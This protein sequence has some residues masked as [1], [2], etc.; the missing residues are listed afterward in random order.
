VATPWQTAVGR[1]PLARPPL[2]TPWQPWQTAVA[3]A[4]GRPPWQTAVA[5]R[6]GRPPWQ[7][8]VADR[9]GRP[10]WQTAV[11]DRRGRPP[12]QTAVADRRGRP[13]WQT[14]VGY[15]V[16][17]MTVLL[18]FKCRS[19][20][21]L[22]R[23]QH[24][25]YRVSRRIC[26]VA[27]YPILGRQPDHAKQSKR[28]AK[29]LA[30]VVTQPHRERKRKNRAAREG[31]VPELLMSVAAVCPLPSGQTAARSGYPDL[32]GRQ[33]ALIR[34]RRKP[35]A[36]AIA[37]SWLF[38]FITRQTGYCPNV[39]LR[40]RS[41][42]AQPRQASAIRSCGSG[43]QPR[44]PRQHPQPRQQPA[45]AASLPRQQPQAR[46]PR[47]RRAAQLPLWKRSARAA[48]TVGSSAAAVTLFAGAGKASIAL[49][50]ARH[51]CFQAAGRNAGTMLEKA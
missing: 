11:A 29:D 46:Q 25:A 51:D 2:A 1:P 14:A 26:T 36:R 49:R 9:R 3:T 16:G 44:P 5:D 10:P 34:T 32:A 4:V 43:R 21:L 6:R 8:A 20:G 13:P 12:W 50:L 31:L 42:T 41:S 48:T 24:K 19:T 28:K 38:R 30:R 33:A 15:A 7:T 18:F 45:S 22:P 35:S 39:A 37:L 17:Y 27:P 40:S 23:A 47:Q